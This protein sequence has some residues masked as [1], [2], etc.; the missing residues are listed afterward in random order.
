MRAAALDHA[1]ADS[2]PDVQTPAVTPVASVNDAADTPAARW[3]AADVLRE[4]QDAAQIGRI[5][6]RTEPPR[7]TVYLDGTE[8]PVRFFP[9]A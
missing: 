9:E 1:T 3:I 7:S 2:A 5:A 8:R 4:L 6:A